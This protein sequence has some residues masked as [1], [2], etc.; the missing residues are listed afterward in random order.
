MAATTGAGKPATAFIRRCP[1]RA[2]RSACGPLSAAIWFRSAPA[3]KNLALPVS[4]SRS[5][6]R[7]ASSS[8]AAVRASTRATVN[9][10]VPSFETSRST[11][12]LRSNCN[13]SESS[14]ADVTLAMIGHREGHRVPYMNGMSIAENLAAVH[15]R[16]ASAARRAGRSADEVLLMAVSKT[17]PAERIVE[18]FESGHRLFGE[19][20]VQEFAD[21]HHGLRQLEGAEF[22]M[23]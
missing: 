19:N 15:E 3:E 4:T 16:I 2:N 14:F 21:K 7:S 10:L 1:M 8:T 18:A 23:I 6:G 17:L 9:R 13:S 11:A 22:H 5:G 12:V 20:R